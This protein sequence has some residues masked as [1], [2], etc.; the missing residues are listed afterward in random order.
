MSSISKETVKAFIAC[1][2]GWN[3]RFGFVMNVDK[4]DFLVVLQN[5]PQLCISLYGSKSG[6][7]IVDFQASEEAF[8]RCDTKEKTRK[9]LLSYSGKIQKFIDKYGK[10]YILEKDFE[11]Y[12]KNIL[13]FGERPQ[14]ITQSI[15][16]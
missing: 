9:M 6:D 1:E 11:E 5:K 13:K 3:Q 8:W 14:T 4:L 10:E 12:Q 2:N 16:E 7:H 15:C